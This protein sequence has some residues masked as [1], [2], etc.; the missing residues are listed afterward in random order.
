MPLDDTRFSS[1]RAA[2][3][4]WFARGHRDLPWRKSRDPYAVWISEIMLQQTRVETVSPRFVRWMARFPTVTALAEA[5]LDAV[6]AEWAGLGYYARARNLHKAAAAIV[7]QHRGRVPDTHEAIRALPGIGPYTA[8]AILSIAYDRSVPL[9]DGNVERVL[10]RLF[11]VEGDPKSGAVKSHLWW[12]AERLVSAGTPAASQH[13]HA[14][15]Q[16]TEPPQTRPSA[17]QLNQGLMELGAVLCTPR[18]P[19]CLACPVEQLCEARRVGD[20]ETLPHKGRVQKVT[21]LEQ[22]AV[23]LLRRNKV[24]LAR[25]PPDGLWG[26]LFEL[27]SGD[28]LPGESPP[29]A[30]RRV[31]AE[32][33]GID[34]EIA[35][36]S[37]LASPADRFEH[38]LSHRRITFHGFVAEA[39]AG[40]GGTVR[41]VFYDAHRWVSPR[42]ASVLG[43]SRATSILLSGLVAGGP[44]HTAPRSHTVTTNK[45]RTSDG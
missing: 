31:A 40:R 9:V 4:G 13:D 43:I 14:A 24:L 18:R 33:T 6:L 1:L 38:V 19:T 41:R 35:A 45:P 25:R 26:G 7:A 3:G 15:S 34:L 23:A 10:A 30:A 37:P 27:P 32:R 21:A 5:P 2:I 8:G 11:H 28:V 12:L 22:V 16:H 39:P 36:L 17:S 29:G 20:A 44:G 42:S